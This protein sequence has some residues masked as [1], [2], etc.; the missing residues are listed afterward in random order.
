MRE[1]RRRDVL[2]TG[3]AALGGV[4][5]TGCRRP[6][7]A[8]KAGQAA[9]D[10]Y[11][12]PDGPQVIAAER[13]RHGGVVRRVRLA[14]GPAT[15]DLGG[16][17]VRTWAYGG[18][19][20]GGVVRVT[21][22]EVLEAAVTNGLPDDT[23][24]HWHG[25]P[26]RDDMDGVP[27]VTQQPIPA[28]ADF[29]YRFTLDQPGTY[30]FHPHVGLQRD[31][32]LYGVLVVDDPKEP[33]SY[34]HEWIVVLDDWLDGVD[35]STP[36]GVLAQ[37]DRAHGGGPRAGSAVPGGAD[38]DSPPPGPG[39]LLTSGHSDLLYGHPGD[40]A[41]PYY[42]V[43]G[44]VPAAPRT[45]TA[46]P[47]DRI[48][49]RIIN[50][51]GDTAFRVALGGHRMTITHTDGRPV[52]HA[53][54]EALLVAMGERY[55]VLVTAGDGVFPLVAL[56]EGKGAA[57][58]AVLRTSPGGATPPADARPAELDGRLVTADRLSADPS[59]ALSGREPDTT[60]RLRLTR[61]MPRYSWG[62][63][64]L[65]YDPRARQPVV[66][67]QRVR[68]S[69][70]NQTPM[71]HPIHLHGH[72]FALPG[73]GPLKDTVIVLPRQSLEVEF[74]ADN[75]GLWLAHCHNVYHAES[76][77]MTVIGYRS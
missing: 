46:R 35:G 61:D 20:P 77:M 33:L 67:G 72:S 23:T 71:W 68:L 39:R 3:L 10:G 52:R 42:L 63:N 24:V 69:L 11:V 40:V 19:V 26:I 7:V 4:V 49:L 48:R 59:V 50:A 13:A 1:F 29:S 66:S 65:G 12:A 6:E 76:G 43:N 27:G 41:Y 5:L 37:L 70:L 47:G 34:D 17:T 45:F 53:G 30:W 2:G 58:R 64:G 28:G 32:G 74:D 31:R 38:A 14:P 21:A 16:P 75:P 73:G 51:G 25:V 36:D 9:P 18:D 57:A 8:G 15:V 22:G 62:F 56:A 60:L 54:T 55:D 44:R